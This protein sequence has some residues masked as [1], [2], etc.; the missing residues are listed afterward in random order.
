MTSSDGKRWT[1][2]DY[3]D[4]AATVARR[5]IGTALI[6]VLDGR[7]VGGIIIETEAYLARGDGA[8]HSRRGKT[9]SNAA[10]FGPPGLSYVYP[11]HTRY[12]FNVS[13]TAIDRGEAVL[14]RAIDP[15][16]GRDVM[17]CRRPSGPDRDL[18][19]GPGRLCEALDIDRRLDGVDLCNSD[20][21]WLE[22]PAVGPSVVVGVTP[23]IGITRDADLPLRFVATE[24]P[25]L[26]GTR[27]LNAAAVRMSD[28]RDPPT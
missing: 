15:T 11:I 5:L 9:R 7:R 13:T 18:T 26:S 1:R 21:L 28:H 17:R 14:I 24:H 10:M 6:R 27:C 16:W 8:A 12:C 25:G 3:A 23:R 19:R 20:R 22:Y 4:D 2:I